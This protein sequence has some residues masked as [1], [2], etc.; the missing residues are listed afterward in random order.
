MDTQSLPQ[1]FPELRTNTF[2]SPW[3]LGSKFCNTLSVLLGACS[4]GWWR[5]FQ[6]PPSLG[7]GVR[8]LTLG[9]W[10]IWRGKHSQKSPGIVPGVLLLIPGISTCGVW[11]TEEA[12]SCKPHPGHSMDLKAW[13]VF[14]LNSVRT[15]LQKYRDLL[16]NNHN[17][18]GFL[19]NFRITAGSACKYK[20]FWFKA[21]VYKSRWIKGDGSCFTLFIKGDLPVSNHYFIVMPARWRKQSN[22]HPK[23]FYNPT[24]ILTEHEINYDWGAKPA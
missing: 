4:R 13:V 1:L 15:T 6:L 9:L 14:R 18:L 10:D 7:G 2:L 22:L 12:V 19:Q 5:T 3:T 17:F 23:A 20:G 16:W 11:V 8:W 21:R 24:L